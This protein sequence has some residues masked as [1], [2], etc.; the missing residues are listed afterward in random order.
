M[1]AKKFH[2]ICGDNVWKINKQV[3][4]IMINYNFHIRINGV[5]LDFTFTK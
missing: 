2:L 4:D 1:A 3:S 5:W